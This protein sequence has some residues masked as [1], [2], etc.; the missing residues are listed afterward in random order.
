MMDEFSEQIM[1]KMGKEFDA[2]GHR[3]R[4]VVHQLI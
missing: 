1:K 2:K 4:Y 3:I